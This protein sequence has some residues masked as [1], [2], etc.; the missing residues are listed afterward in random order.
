[1]LAYVPD[2]VERSIQT[3]PGRH[4]GPL[5]LAEEMSWR[6]SPYRVGQTVTLVSRQ[7]H[8][9]IGDLFPVLLQRYATK[10]IGSMAKYFAKKRST[11]G[12]G[13]GRYAKKKT[14][15]RVSKKSALGSSTKLKTIVS[16]EIQKVLN[17]GAQNERRKVTMEMKLPCKQIF[18]N[19]DARYNSC[20][21]VPITSA[22][23]AMACTSQAPDV[24]RRGANKVVVTGVNLRMSLSHADQVR[25]MAVIYEP[26]E[27]MRANLKA[28]GI[29]TFPDAGLGH[30][31]EQFGTQMA[32][33]PAFGLVSKHG[34]FMTKK[35]GGG[36]EK[37]HLAL[38][39]VDGTPFE[40][41]TSTHAGKPIA[42]LYRKSF[43]GKVLQRTVNWDQGGQPDS[44]GLGYTNWTREVINEYWK[45]NKEYTY[46]HEGQNDQVFERCAEMLLYVD[47]PSLQCD[48]PGIPDEVPLVGAVLGSVVIDIYHHDK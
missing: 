34:P 40:C 32:P 6:V 2:S 30:V 38:D 8:V 12:K 24:R 37:P 42:P 11:G 43:G 48:D 7:G 33:Y 39:S 31:P 21:R 36:T 35:S 16:N 23:P 29:Q 47:C 22:I 46:V 20:I 4:V 3:D 15:G 44:T 5:T 10:T 13:G 1:M 41:R 18:I 26:H 14:A 25:V 45:L 9:Y 17:S 19:G 28:V 27:S